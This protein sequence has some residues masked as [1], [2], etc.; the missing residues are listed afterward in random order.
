MLLAFTQPVMF[1]VTPRPFSLRLLP[2]QWSQTIWMNGVFLHHMLYCSFNWACLVF[3]MF[4][5]CMF[6]YC[7]SQSWDSNQ[8]G[9]IQQFSKP[10]ACSLW[11]QEKIKWA[12]TMHSCT[13]LLLF[14]DSSPLLEPYHGQQITC[15]FSF[16][17][18]FCWRAIA[19]LRIFRTSNIYQIM[20]IRTDFHLP[21]YCFTFCSFQAWFPQFTPMYWP[22][23]LIQQ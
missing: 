15:S 10:L 20:F 21:K 22:C 3:F 9:K 4:T 18:S 19:C 5:F 13:F 2:K 16:S 14:M 17:F 6:L 23:F 8:R 7:S 12:T 11:S 1:T